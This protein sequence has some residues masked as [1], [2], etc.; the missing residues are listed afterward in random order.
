MTQLDSDLIARL[1]H[2]TYT[3]PDIATAVHTLTDNIMS[4][5]ISF[6]VE[7]MDMRAEAQRWYELHWYPWVRR[8]LR[9]LWVS[10]FAAVAIEH[11]D[12]KGY[13]GIPVVLDLAMLVIEQSR[14]LT[15]RPKFV[16]Y[17][18]QQ[19]LVH[20]RPV[21]LR[22]IRTYVHSPPSG[23]GVI[24][25]KVS[26]LLSDIRMIHTLNV[27]RIQAESQRSDPLVAIED[28]H[29]PKGRSPS[30]GTHALGTGMYSDLADHMDD[31]LSE[32]A[33]QSISEDYDLEHAKQQRGLYSKNLADTFAAAHNNAS[34]STV[35][36]QQ[37]QATLLG[38]D[39]NRG[40][41]NQSN[42]VY[43]DGSNHNHNDNEQGTRRRVPKYMRVPRQKHIVHQVMAQAPT[44]AVFVRT[45]VSE[46]VSSVFGI[47]P[48]LNGHRH[49]LTQQSNNRNSMTLFVHTL[50]QWRRTIIP[51]IQNMYDWIDSLE[52]T[53]TRYNNNNNNNNNNNSR[54]THDHDNDASQNDSSHMDDDDDDDV[55]QYVQQQQQQQQQQFGQD[56]EQRGNGYYYEEEEKGGEAEEPT[57]EWYQHI[58]STPQRCY[59]TQNECNEEHRYVSEW[60]TTA[61]N[62]SDND[63]YNNSTS[64]DSL[65]VVVSMPGSIPDSILKEWY[66]EKFIS[67]AGVYAH[68]STKYSIR[69]EH[70][71]SWETSQ[72]TTTTRHSSSGSSNET[73]E[74]EDSAYD[75]NSGDER[76]DDN[77]ND[78][79]SEVD[80]TAEPKQ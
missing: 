79:D 52:T 24:R 69:D 13:H 70:L 71:T 62:D 8:L 22:G 2:I 1:D 27:Y 17:D 12:T 34:S 51:L 66:K 59:A 15:G 44:D 35:F 16:Y 37:L 38:H 64:G 53:V 9:S 63:E 25:S 21:R 18:P 43:A 46:R 60:L 55:D 65:R 39:F 33:M 74:D 28:T 76:N 20:G 77:A 58:E 67:D 7:G 49:G 50:S 23:E 42:S 41:G 29:L 48:G 72:G 4:G 40:G 32:I 78:V 31:K 80:N 6:C 75:Y 30:S 10:G 61:G 57:M 45:T 11:T 14:T 36:N 19:P 5:G 26:C 54:Y 68:L 3:H 47:P 73:S 56:E